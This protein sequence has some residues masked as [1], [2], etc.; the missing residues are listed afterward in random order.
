MLPYC[1]QHIAIPHFFVAD[2]AFP[3]REN[4][5]R[6]YSKPR[7][8]SLSREE[9]IF[10]YRLSR[11][12][13]V[14]ENTF[15]IMT[16]RFRILHRV[17]NAHPK[18]ADNIMKAIVCLHNFIRKENTSFYIQEGDLDTEAGSSI[19]PGKWRNDIPVVGTAL[20][21]IPARLGSRNASFSALAVR[22]HLKH[23]LNGPGSHLAPWQWDILDRTN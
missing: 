12:R 1:P 13:R 15:G 5:M 23:Y 21:N 2:E 20:T 11:A 16:A 22:N 3:L 17:M 14:I 19:K 6:P 9:S 7:T 4:I 10:N 8:G 18:T